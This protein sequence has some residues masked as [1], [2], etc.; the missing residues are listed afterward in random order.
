MASS[1]SC[2]LLRLIGI[3]NGQ[4]EGEHRTLRLIALDLDISAV[5][6]HDFLREVQ[7]DAG[8]GDSRGRAG[9][10]EP[11]EDL[12]DF[13]RRDADAP[14]AHRAIGARPV[15][16]DLDL[17]NGA[18]PEYFTAL[19]KRLMTTCSIRMLSQW[20]AIGRSGASNRISAWELISRWRSQIS[21]TSSL[22]SQVGGIQLDPAG[23][24]FRRIQ[25]AVH[26]SRQAAGGA[27]D[28]LNPDHEL[29]VARILTAPQD[30]LGTGIEDGQGVRNWWETMETKL[31]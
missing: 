2:R 19:D 5:K 16:P 28:L 9:P 30:A 20:T 31:R 12:G 29:V 14:I 23:I 6:M 27:A 7:P 21:R 18:S 8:A 4:V 24:E 15:D 26:K 10:V 11:V 25:H 3:G 13:V 1:P 22:R 17:D